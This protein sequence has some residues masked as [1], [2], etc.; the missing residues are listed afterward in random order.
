M[1]LRFVIISLPLILCSCHAVR[2]IF[3]NGPELNDYRFFPNAELEPDKTTF[4]FEENIQNAVGDKI[5]VTPINKNHQKISP[6]SLNQHFDES[7]VVGMLIIRNDTIVY[8]KYDPDFGQ[9][10]HY[11]SFSMI[12]SLGLS[13]LLA[14]TVEEGFV[15]SL[16]D[17]VTKYIPEL[18]FKPDFDKVTLQHLL[19]FK[20]GIQEGKNAAFPF[21]SQTRGYYGRHLEKQFE[22]MKIGRE[23][24]T[25]YK[26]SMT[27]ESHLLGEVIR[28]TTG[29]DIEALFQEKIWS[30]IGTEDIAIWSKDRA[31]G[32]VKSFC[33]FHAK[34]RDYARLGRLFL[35]QGKWE[36]EQILPEFWI[37]D[38]YGCVDECDSRYEIAATEINRDYNYSHWFLGTKGYGEI[39]ASGLFGQY[40]YVFPRENTLMIT[41]TNRVGLS[42]GVYQVDIHYEILEQLSLFK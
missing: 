33:C 23:P 26:Y 28:R 13:P 36:D 31:Q 2:T 1:R 12:K 20:G 9:D 11:A 35:N 24:G 16:N 4:Y 3:R 17:P 5:I 8:E 30:K 32:Q 37:N 15:E 6:R 14:I 38:I 27:A 25:S 34:S 40:V 18:K 29:K 21:S 7:P 41:F 22:K 10:F 39:K 19:D 42:R